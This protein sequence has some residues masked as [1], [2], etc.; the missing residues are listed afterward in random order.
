MRRWNYF[1]HGL[2]VSAAFPVREWDA[3]ENAETSAASDV[4]ISLGD[5]SV[6]ASEAEYRFSVPDLGSVHVRG[7]REIEVAPLPGVQPDRL[8]PWLAGSAWAALCYQRGFLMLHASAVAFANGAIAFCGPAQ[9]GK[10]TLAAHL[11]ALG[12]ALVGDDLCRVELPA[13]RP[14]II[15]PSAPRF[16][17]SSHT[18]AGLD[19][20]IKTLQSDVDSRTGKTLLWTRNRSVNPLPLRVIY[21]LNWG[22][23]RQH[24]LTG[25]AALRGLLLAGSYRG[26]LIDSMKRS[27]AHVQLCVEFLRRVPVWELTRPREL[28]RMDEIVRFVTDRSAAERSFVGL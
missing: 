8:H 13:A 16:K 10:S 18:L 20:D 11:H 4:V 7:G 28:M 3:F 22:E 26:D 2:S 6:P 25:S 19:P 24:Q 17:L 14:A 21:L 5:S 23:W 27:A 12:H 15:Y 1:Y 9:S